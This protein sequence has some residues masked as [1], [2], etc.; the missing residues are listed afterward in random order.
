MDAETHPD[1]HTESHKNA[2]SRP[3]LAVLPYPLPLKHEPPAGVI[4]RVYT[5]QKVSMAR[6][7]GD[8]PSRRTATAKTQR[9]PKPRGQYCRK[10]DRLSRRRFFAYAAAA[11]ECRNEGG[12]LKE[13]H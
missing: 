6:Q 12:D 7:L 4:W 11:G 10:A 13:V 9:R 1:G 3:E 5:E 8:Q 2:H